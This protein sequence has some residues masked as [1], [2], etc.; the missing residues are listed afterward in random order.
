MEILNNTKYDRDLIIRYN[1]YYSKSYML[2]NFI[3]ITVISFGFAIYMLVQQQWGY[4]ALLI[5]ILIAYYLLTWLM[6]KLTTNRMLKKSPLVENPMLQTYLFKDDGFDVTN[7]KSYTVPYSNI[8][9][10][11]QSKDFFMIQTQDRKTYIVDFKG[12]ANSYDEQNLREF[13]NKMF[14]LKLKSIQ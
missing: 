10:I 6:Q 12:F 13:F 2:K 11:K 8:A 14:N 4:A 7:V 3:I 1:K 9:T 5:G